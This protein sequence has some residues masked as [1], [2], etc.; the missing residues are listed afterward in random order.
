MKTIKQTAEFKA[1]PHEIFE[2]LMDSKKHSKLTGSKAE[3]DRKVGGKFTAY[4]GGLNGK[5]L[6][7]VKDK[8]IVQA[9]RCEM[10]EWNKGYYS[11]ATFLLKKS[12]NGTK[13]EF[14]QTG[15]PDKAYEDISEGWKEYYW[16][17]MKKMLED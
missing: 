13:L 9:W 17:K 1:S 14:T 3:I 8:K 6:E 7:I 5:N 15:V 11:K 2:L 10:E 4:D 12:K 16:K